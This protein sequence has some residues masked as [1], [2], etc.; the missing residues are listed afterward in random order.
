[1]LLTQLK[2]YDQIYQVATSAPPTSIVRPVTMMQLILMDTRDFTVPGC[3]QTAQDEL[4]QYMGTVIQAFLAYQAGE[5]EATIRDLV[6]ESDAHYDKFA[7]EIETVRA[8]APL[9]LR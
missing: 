6:D 4:V 3:M 2:R 8:C 9:C 7:T 1:M 5:A